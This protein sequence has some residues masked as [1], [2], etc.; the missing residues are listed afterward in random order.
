[1]YA[2]LDRKQESSKRRRLTSYDCKALS[3]AICWL[4][5]V[6]PPDVIPASLL[7]FAGCGRALHNT[8]CA[9]ILR[10]PSCMLAFSGDACDKLMPQIEMILKPSEC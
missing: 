2:K 4:L 9:K 3:R 8:C 5:I 7:E 1:M 10:H 6:C